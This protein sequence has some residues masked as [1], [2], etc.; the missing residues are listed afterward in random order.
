MSQRQP[1]NVMPKLTPGILLGVNQVKRQK[2]EGSDL[3]NRNST[4]KSIEIIVNF[5]NE[6]Q[7]YAMNKIIYIV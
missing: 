7:G 4:Y 5:R 3:K 1:E 2:S 6:S